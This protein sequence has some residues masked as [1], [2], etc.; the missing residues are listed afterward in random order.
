MILK[1]PFF[2]ICWLHVVR[3]ALG[4]VE[5][6]SGINSPRENT[7]HYGLT[8]SNKLQEFTPYTIYISE[9]PDGDKVEVLR[10]EYGGIRYRRYTPKDGVVISS[11]KS[12]GMELCRDDGCQNFKL[13]ESFEWD[14]FVVISLETRGQGM[15]Y[16]GNINGKWEDVDENLVKELKEVCGTFSA[17]KAITLDLLAIPKKGL[18]ISRPS[19]GHPFLTIR[20]LPNVL[21]K[22]IIDGPYTLWVG[23]GGGVCPLTSFLV[24][25]GTPILAEI[26]TQGQELEDKVYYL[27]RRMFG[28]YQITREFY[29]FLVERF[30]ADS[31]LVYSHH[32]VLLLVV[33]SMD[34]F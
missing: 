27:E 6:V 9:D 28:W 30:S 12:H 13:L 10:G 25:G 5:G 11:V 22:R 26:Y 16:F 3:C 4:D 2:I 15:R 23:E 21:I 34:A 1:G 19:K 33:F 29:E 7:P 14:D 8:T 31:F 32:I 20:P 24:K 17:Q 18:E